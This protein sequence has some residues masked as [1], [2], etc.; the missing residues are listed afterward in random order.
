MIGSSYHRAK[1]ISGAVT[2]ADDPLQ[3]CFGDRDVEA[4]DRG[5][6]MNQTKPSETHLLDKAWER[7]NALEG[8]YLSDEVSRAYDKA[9]DQALA[10][11]E[12]LGGRDPS[13]RKSEGGG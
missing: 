1:A 10:I 9:I 6:S 13:T 2:K 3:E 8:H 4:K 5:I 12:D 11:I 7:I